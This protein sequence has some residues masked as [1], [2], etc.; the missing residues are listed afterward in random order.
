MVC[1]SRRWAPNARPA[2]AYPAGKP[3]SPGTTSSASSALA[4]QTMSTAPPAARA[5]PRAPPGSR[6]AARAGA[7][8]PRPPRGRGRQR[9]VALRRRVGRREERQQFHR[10]SP[11]SPPASTRRSV[12]ISPNRLL[13]ISPARR[14]DR[15]PVVLRVECVVHRLERVER[16]LG[17][18]VEAGVGQERP[19]VGEQRVVLHVPAEAGEGPGHAACSVAQCAWSPRSRA[20]RPRRH[21]DPDDHGRQAT[22]RGS[23]FLPNG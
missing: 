23:R 22:G 4:N 16:E 13:S 10:A 9:R 8:R 12:S 20:R 14:R 21:P 15:P 11:G 6:A 17:A 1:A 7:A 3:V 2:S 18:G 19:A 5:G